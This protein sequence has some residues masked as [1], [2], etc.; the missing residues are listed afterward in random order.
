MNVTIDSFV[1]EV[2]EFAKS[3]GFSLV[4]DTFDVRDLTIATNLVVTI[5]FTMLVV[6]NGIDSFLTNL[7]ALRQFILLGATKVHNYKWG[8]DR[9]PVTAT[10]VELSTNVTEQFGKGYSAI[11]S[12][13]INMPYL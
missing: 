2:V 4:L 10:P 3:R 1:T 6:D 12:V 7:A 13:V 11:V 5:N 9:K 8:L